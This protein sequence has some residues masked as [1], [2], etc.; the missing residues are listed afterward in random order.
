M[1]WLIK[2]LADKNEK[3]LEYAEENEY[4]SDTKYRS[5]ENKSVLTAINR[6]LRKIECT[7]FNRRIIFFDMPSPF[8]HFHEVTAKFK[9]PLPCFIKP[10]FLKEATKPH[11]STGN[12][13]FLTH[14]P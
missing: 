5:I 11:T 12:T 7:G 2:Y 1:K 9:I 6:I 3:K 13:A 14:T 4:M 10:A 8:H